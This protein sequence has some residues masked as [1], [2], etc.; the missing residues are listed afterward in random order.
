MG[1]KEESDRRSAWQRRVMKE[2]TNFVFGGSL[3]AETTLA[4]NSEKKGYC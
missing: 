3:L 1:E 4:V 2:G